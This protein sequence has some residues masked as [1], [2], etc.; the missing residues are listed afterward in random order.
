[1]LVS[2]LEG[3]PEIEETLTASFERLLER[4]R[5]MQRQVRIGGPAAAEDAR[6][7]KAGDR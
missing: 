5:A 1:M 4:Y 7:A 6:A 3:R 2:R